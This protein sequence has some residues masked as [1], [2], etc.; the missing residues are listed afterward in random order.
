MPAAG[1][2]TLEYW[3]RGRHCDFSDDYSSGVTDFG[4]CPLVED[5][6]KGN[7]C[8]DLLKTILLV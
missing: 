7:G 4:V 8:L 5:V 3:K 6:R 1:A 2:R